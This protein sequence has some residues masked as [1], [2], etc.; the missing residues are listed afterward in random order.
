MT[1]TTATQDAFKITVAYKG[2]TQEHII[3][4]MALC[5]IPEYV[6]RYIPE[7]KKASIRDIMVT[8]VGHYDHSGVYHVG[9]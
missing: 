9:L 4:W 2:T 6:L 5:N 3:P 8:F 1:G 7:Y